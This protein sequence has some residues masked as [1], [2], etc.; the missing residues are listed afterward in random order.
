MVSGIESKVGMPHT[1]WNDT[2][3]LEE[4]IIDE[5]QTLQLAFMLRINHESLGENSENDDDHADQC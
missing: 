1:K 4:A 3:R 5:E 2:H